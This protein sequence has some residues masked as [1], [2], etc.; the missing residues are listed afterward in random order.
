[1]PLSTNAPFNEFGQ[2]MVLRDIE[3]LYLLLNGAGTG[4]AGDGQ[5]QDQAGA[6]NQEQDLSGLATT[7]YVDA[8]IAAISS[9]QSIGTY[10]VH[11]F[12]SITPS[13]GTF[14]ASYSSSD[15]NAAS[16]LS[17]NVFTAPQSGVYTIIS[18]VSGYWGGAPNVNI[19]TTITR[20]SKSVP[21]KS[22]SATGN[23]G[24]PIFTVSGVAP[25]WTSFSENL[26]ATASWT[27]LLVSGETITITHYF[28]ATSDFSGSSNRLLISGICP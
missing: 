6:V 28:S 12:G 13:I 3:Q 19:M 23:L 4:S 22:T 7:D 14:N 24:L 27:G 16:S 20:D 8:A 1:M 5:T 25:V 26:D 11:A 21:L 18:R 15:G 17:G 10:E 9:P 2:S